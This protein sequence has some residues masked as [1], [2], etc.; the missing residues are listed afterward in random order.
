MGERVLVFT[1]RDEVA[2]LRLEV[3]DLRAKESSLRAEVTKLRCEQGAFK[4]RQVR[5]LE[6][7]RR[8]RRLAIMIAVDRSAILLIGA[9][10]G[11]AIGHNP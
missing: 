3:A 9:V 5:A 7:A 6:V 8:M 4:G 11:Y 10:L 2:P 1:P